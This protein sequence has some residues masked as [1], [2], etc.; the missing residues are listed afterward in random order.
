MH[1]KASANKKSH[2]SKHKSKKTSKSSSSSKCFELAIEIVAFSPQIG[3]ILK[4]LLGK[5]VELLAFEYTEDVLERSLQFLNALTV[6]AFTQNGPITEELVYLSKIFECL[7]LGPAMDVKNEEQSVPNGI[8]SD[9]LQQHQQQA[10]MIKLEN[11]NEFPQSVHQQAES[12]LPA[13]DLLKDFRVENDQIIKKECEDFF[14]MMD[15]SD[16]V[17]KKKKRNKLT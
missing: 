16:T 6:N 3:P 2:G 4:L 10:D 7:L 9:H 13:E 8:T 5:C 15:T 17:I 14:M 12:L 11:P 1:S